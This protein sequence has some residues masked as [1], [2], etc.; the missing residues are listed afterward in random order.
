MEPEPASYA[1]YS[2]SCII[3]GI[4]LRVQCAWWWAGG[5]ACTPPRETTLPHTHAVGR[6]DGGK[7]Q[8]MKQRHQHQHQRSVS[9]AKKCQPSDS[10]GRG[11]QTT[12]QTAAAMGIPKAQHAK[13]NTTPQPCRP[14]SP[15]G[16]EASPPPHHIMP[17]VDRLRPRSW[18][19]AEGMGERHRHQRR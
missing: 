18:G 12:L 10:L 6:G 14:M 7:Q 5:C 11:F 19:L 2:W 1:I 16:S 3:S 15:N 13:R 17:Q 4:T 9:V 8:K